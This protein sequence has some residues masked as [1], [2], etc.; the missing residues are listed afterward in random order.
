MIA[1]Y[2]KDHSLLPRLRQSGVLVVYD[3]ERRYHALC[4]G[5]ANE[6]TKVVDTSES[7]ILGREQALATLAAVGTSK[8]GVQQLLVYVPALPPRSD[9]QKQRDPFALYTACGAVFP[10]GDGDTYL[11]LCLKAKP[12]QATE[13]RKIFDQNPN[14]DFAVIDALG[15]GAG[16]P[17]LRALLGVESA[18]GILYALMAPSESQENALRDREDWVAE[19]RDLFQHSLGLKLSTRGKTLASIGDELWRFLLFSEFVFDLPEALPESLGAMPK[20]PD[21]ARSVVEALCDR[22]RNDARSRDRYIQKAEAAEQELQ[23]PQRCQHLH[24][25]GVRDTFPFEE[26]HFLERAVDAL[27]AENLDAVRGILGHRRHSVW[28]SRGDSRVDWDLI[29]TTLRLVETA[30]DCARELPQHSRNLET[31]TD[32]YT[33]RL[34]QLDRL[35]REYEQARLD[36]TLDRA[37]PERLEDFARQQYRQ[38]AAAAHDLFIRFVEQGEYPLPGRLSSTQVFD[39]K[40]GPSLQASGR[41][42]A[43]ILVDALRYELG[44]TLEKQLSDEGQVEL[45]AA[46]AALPTATK[47][48]MVS[49]LPGG[50]TLNLKKQAGDL[51]VC[52]GD[53]PIGTVPQ[54]MDVFRQRYGQRFAETTLQDFVQSRQKIDPAVDLLVIRSTE[55]DQQMETAPDQALSQV[56]SSLKRIRLAINRLRKEKFQEVVVATDHGFF[57]NLN[58]PPGDVCTKPTG[59]W[60]NVH[61]RL[62]L[63]DGAAAS[64]HFLAPAS[65]LSIR[66]DFNQVAGPRGL[67]AFSK[68]VSYFHGGLSL[69][70]CIV[71]VLS[72]RLSAPAAP[73]GRL[74]VQ[75]SYKNGARRIT[76]RFPVIDVA[77]ELISNDL[78]AQEN[79]FELYMEAYDGK[80]KLVG[81]AKRSDPVDPATGILALKANRSVQVTLR[82]EDDFEGKFTIKAID[83]KNQA[84]YDSLSLET[85]YTV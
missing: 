65:R 15:A 12:D 83:P 40:V 47:V 52:L 5:L 58:P 69:Q 67:V 21:A 81:E 76:T 75:L 33:S 18:S 1:S 49:L 8:A 71:P 20:A 48:G 37:V 6:Q 80:G 2:I 3:P 72:V 59:T 64:T 36:F 78:F 34:C 55:I 56:F 19:A 31:L 27:L 30:D 29:S 23:L 85:D 41:K 4:L 22:L 63:G 26:R 9:D 73:E 45:H 11:S 82:M 74:K 17:I 62:L 24:D 39:K 51:Q 28:A 68:G 61:D 54:R 25:L 44:E 14:P 60:V 7:S 53:T 16:Y 84:T 66:G 57:L 46:F 42:V 13:I 77:L 35:H 70:E 50:S 10:D 79:Y 43:Y 32:F 38:V